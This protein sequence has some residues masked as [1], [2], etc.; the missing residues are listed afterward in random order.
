MTESYAYLGERA[1]DPDACHLVGT[2][3]SLPVCFAYS[4]EGAANIARALSRASVETPP[5][6]GQR[7]GM[8]TPRI[9][10]RAAELL[11]GHEITVRELR[12]IPYVVHTMT[13]NQRIDPNKIN[14]EEREILSRW[15]KAGHIEG[16]AGGLKITREFWDVCCELLFLGYVDLDD[17]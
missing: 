1:V 4:A 10:K 8:V 13:N 6:D 14:A 5:C 9:A 2:T 3:M 17:A 11:G 7:R 12:L 15:R 16:G